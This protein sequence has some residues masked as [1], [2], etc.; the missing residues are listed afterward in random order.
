MNKLNILHIHSAKHFGGGEV[1]LYQLAKGLS[2][3]GHNLVLAIREPMV[4][5]F[6]GLDVKIEE[7]PLRNVLDLS[8]ISQLVKIIKENKIDIIHVHRGKGYWL[9]VISVKLARRG[10]VVATRHILR[11][12]GKGYV[13]SRLYENISRFIAVSNEV[14]NILVQENKIADDKIAVIYNG[15]NIENFN[16]KKVDN[17]GLKQEFGLKNNELVVGTVGRLGALKNQELLVKMAAKLKN[18]AD[19]KY[20]I[21][22]EDNSS[23]QSYKHRLE[24]LIKEFKL[25]DKVVLTGFRRDIPELMSLFDILV[26]P[27]QEES[28][29]IVA[30]EAMAMKKPVVASDVGGLKE[31]IQD[32]KTGFLVP[33]VEK[34]FIGRLLKLIN[35]SNLR[36]KMG[37]TGY[38]RVLNKFTIEAMIDQTEELYFSC[39]LWA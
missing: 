26:V 12:L 8:S 7:L 31:I 27:S 28:F 15:V 24:D 11:S 9:G 39:V 13:Y 23:N 36:K 1:H 14:K 34:E 4:D 6:S 30:I 17:Q 35:N 25:E 2:A 20:L 22:G 16:T 29:G 32:N 37:Q 18:K 19:V 10:K 38:E 3:R 5:K 21:V 33:L